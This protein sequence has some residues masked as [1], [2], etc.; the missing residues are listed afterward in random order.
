MAISDLPFENVCTLLDSVASTRGANGKVTKLVSVWKKYIDEDSYPIMRLLLPTIDI[1]RGAFGLRESVIARIYIDALSLADKGE[2]AMRLRHYKDPNYFRGK[3][4]GQVGDFSSTVYNTVKLRCPRSD[5]C[6]IGQT[7]EMLDRMTN[8]NTAIDYRRI[9]IHMLS[10]Y[11][12]RE[13]FWIVRII[14][15]DLKLGISSSS[16]LNSFHSNAMDVFNSTSSLKKVCAFVLDPLTNYEYS[17]LR[18][19]NPVRPML[20]SRFQREKLVSLLSNCTIAVEVKYDGE[21]VHVHK[22]DDEIRLYS[23]NCVDLTDRYGYGQLLRN[24]LV[25]QVSA[26][27]CILDAELVSYSN[28]TGIIQPFGS[29][30]GAI[31]SILHTSILF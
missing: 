4:A 19:M 23:R 7:N 31:K 21:R 28:T 15:K 18:P 13:H 29:N 6:T 11:G 22:Q 9:F 1:D 12:A 25:S 16:I 3:V 27:S 24:L 14:L 2:A 20:S 10:H 26:Q 17:T 5:G 8:A 30:R